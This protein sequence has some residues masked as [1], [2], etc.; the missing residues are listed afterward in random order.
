VNP[1][2]FTIGDL[3]VLAI[4]APLAVMCFYGALLYVNGVIN[5]TR[6]RRAHK[7]DSDGR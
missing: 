5:E 4:A 1:G 6:D 7:G 2:D 3:F